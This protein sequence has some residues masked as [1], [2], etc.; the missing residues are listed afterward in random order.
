MKLTYSGEKAD[1]KLLPDSREMAKTETLA[2]AIQ[3]LLYAVAIFGELSGC[4]AIELH[5][6]SIIE[7]RNLK[8]EKN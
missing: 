5:S 4:L 6:S 2:S 8:P 1:I 7:S 3:K